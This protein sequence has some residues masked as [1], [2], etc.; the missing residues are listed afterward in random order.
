MRTFSMLALPVLLLAGCSGSRS[1]T[2]DSPDRTR[3]MMLRVPLSYGTGELT[4]AAVRLAIVA[5]A[6]C[7][8]VSPCDAR[9]VRVTFLNRSSRDVRLRFVPIHIEAD[10]VG[11][12]VPTPNVPQDQEYMPAGA[13]FSTLLRKEFVPTFAGAQNVMIRLGQTEVTLSHSERQPL[14]DLLLRLDTPGSGR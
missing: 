8:T 9:G 3:E 11:Y 4:S 1:S 10:G 5:E 13:F 12:D 6:E 14:R 2:G 7:L